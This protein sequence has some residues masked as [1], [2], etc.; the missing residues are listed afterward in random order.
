MSFSDGAM[1]PCFKTHSSRASTHPK[2]CA[3]SV[4]RLW[5]PWSCSRQT[6]SGPTRGR[7]APLPESL[8]EQQREDVVRGCYEMLMVQA[9]AVA[10]PLPGES[11][12]SQA[13][14]AL[15]ILE[16]AVLLLHQP[17]HAYHLRRA[18][19]LEQGRRRRGGEA[20]TS[21]GRSYANRTGH[22]TTS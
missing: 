15:Q 16:R 21:D 18:A 10:Q 4:S 13:R 11:A 7:L 8:T 1:T 22:S 2:T 5:R 3:V 17:T 12:T 14:E 19:C 20:G 6:A 9:E